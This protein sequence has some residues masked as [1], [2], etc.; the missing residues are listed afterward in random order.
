[1]PATATSL[2]TQKY[3][4]SRATQ[5]DNRYCK[6]LRPRECQEE[7]AH[8]NV[9]TLEMQLELELEVQLELEL[10]LELELVHHQGFATATTES[11]KTRFSTADWR[12]KRAT[13]TRGLAT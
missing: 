9:R 5:C 2:H 11:T 7:A 8:D 6:Q 13:A 4:I 1:M 12:R 10:E 3:I